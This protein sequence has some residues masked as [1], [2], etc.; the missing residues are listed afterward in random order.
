MEGNRTEK[1]LDIVTSRPGSRR[2]TSIKK[3][4]TI[5]SRRKIRIGFMTRQ[6]QILIA[7]LAVDQDEY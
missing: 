3:R 6:K 5:S 1:P 7:G 4:K 2:E